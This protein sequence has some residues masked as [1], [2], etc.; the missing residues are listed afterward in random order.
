MRRQTHTPVL[1]PH[2][3]QNDEDQEL[4]IDWT[5]QY[6][7]SPPSAIRPKAQNQSRRHTTG[8]VGRSDYYSQFLKRYRSSEPGETDDPRNDP[9][10]HY[11]QRGLN[12]LPDVG[13]KDSDD[14]NDPSR[15][16]LLPDS[17]EILLEN[18]AGS[19]HDKERLVWRAYLV[20]VL[21]GDILRSERAR[22][23]TALE[24]SGEE[25]HAVR[26]A[27]WLEIRAKFHDSSKEEEET[28]LN[29]RRVHVVDPVI[30]DINAFRASSPDPTIT[31]GEIDTLLNNL[32]IAQSLYPSMRAFYLDKPKATEPKF[33]AR[34][35]ALNT[36]ATVFTSLRRHISVLQRW[37]GS[38]TLDVTQSNTSP[39]EPTIADMKDGTSFVERVLKEES[40]QRMF[41]K[42]ALVT[43]HMSIGAA[44]DAQV[45]LATYFQEMNLPTFESQLVPL[46][47][48]PTRFVQASLRVRLD[49][50]QK[51]RD[52][53][54]LIIDQMIEDLKLGIGLACT[55]KRQYEGFLL[56]DPSGK[57]NVPQCI[58]HDFDQTILEAIKLFFRL[59]HWKLKGGAKGGY[60]KETDVLDSQWA[61]LN[62]VSMTI[63][64]GSS[65]I[66]EQLW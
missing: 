27:I 40:M 59:I 20:S 3:E 46:I 36:W 30:S 17:L 32:D 25:R 28:R 41:E 48:F 12:Q 11:F 18:D 29:E 58:S 10:S 39:E 14:E 61:T 47:S 55:L 1:Y 34:R 65:L 9:D 31:L 51:L 16:S 53:E 21:N 52:P 13:D 54:L 22:I 35:D 60:F 44:R 24:S 64:G 50:V 4:D 23:A 49:Y 5:P 33:Q 43:L 56:P 42:S 26:T 62:D 57:W 6:S 45:N 2:T 38:D 19:E 63:Q 66:A 15:A 7:S 37:T 8:G